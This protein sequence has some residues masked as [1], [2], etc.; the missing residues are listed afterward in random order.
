M[1]PKELQVYNHVE[2]LPQEVRVAEN[3]AT[4]SR[5]TPTPT[6]QPNMA[7]Q[8]GCR[9]DTFLSG[10]VSYID[11]D[12]SGHLVLCVLSRPCYPTFPLL[13]RQIHR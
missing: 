6:D 11:R 5:L 1:L 10:T 9:E 8:V 13:S 7:G 12:V 2:T 3:S 4:S